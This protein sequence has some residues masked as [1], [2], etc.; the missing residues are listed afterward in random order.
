MGEG[1]HALGKI[2]LLIL[3]VDGVLTNGIVFLNETGTE[4]KAFHLRDGH[5][6]KLLQ[7][8]GIGIVLLSGR[9]SEATLRRAEELGIKEVYQGIVDKLPLYEKVL[10]DKG[11]E[12]DEVAY[13]GDDLMDLPLL[14]RAGFGAT[15]ADGIE[16]A[17]EVAEYVATK[18]GGEGA[19]REVIE[20]ILK[21]QGKWQ[22]VTA[23]YFQCMPNSILL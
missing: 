19:V 7:K 9:Y 2:K 17:K 11:L 14:R 22:E 6:I 12:D 21:S 1:C 5:G 16:E 10:R 8:C 20:L 3:D 15:V 18:K 23:R 4:S 13:M